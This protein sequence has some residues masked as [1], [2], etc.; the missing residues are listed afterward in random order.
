MRFPSCHT[1]VYGSHQVLDIAFRSLDRRF[2]NARWF[3]PHSNKRLAHL[4]HDPLAHGEMNLCR[5]AAQ[6]YDP[7]FLWQCSI[8]V[9]GSPCSMCTCAIFYT[10][11]GRIVHATSIYDKQDY[12]VMDLPYLGLSPLEILRR[13][14]KDIVI[15]GPYPELAEECMKK[16]EH[17]D[18]SGIEFYA[19]SAHHLMKR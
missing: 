6:K 7:E 8:Y 13:G 16:F 4:F 18:P 3:K 1:A 15:D 14:N 17:F 5:E 19:K 9:P 10:N 12:T 11:I 2:D